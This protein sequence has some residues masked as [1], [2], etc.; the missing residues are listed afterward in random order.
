[1]GSTSIQR[2]IIISSED[3]IQGRHLPK[4]SSLNSY[5]IPSRFETFASERGRSI[6]LMTKESGRHELLGTS[7]SV[8]VSRSDWLDDLLVSSYGR[9]MLLSAPTS[10]RCL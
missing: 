9:R 7:S 4:R 5:F 6:S 2:S 3:E 1:M 10:L 8:L